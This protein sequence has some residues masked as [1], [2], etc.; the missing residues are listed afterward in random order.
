MSEHH[1]N[2]AALEALLF[3]HGEPLVVAKIQE[4]LK[5]SAEEVEKL[6]EE[7]SKKYESPGHGVRLLLHGA[8][9]QLITKPEYGELLEYFVKEELAEEL[10]PASLETL[11][12]VAYLG[13][14]P[15][16]RIEYLRGVN[17]SFTLRSL[18][19]RGLVER[20]ADPE[21]P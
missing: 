14:L 11:A 1:N 3:I 16:S 5:V 20:V 4:V 9:A 2:V 21:R 13:P 17:S 6:L 8:K 12:L 15:R 7:L 19:V 18:L 10:T